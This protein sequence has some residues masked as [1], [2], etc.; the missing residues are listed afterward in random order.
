MVENSGGI[1]SEQRMCFYVSVN[2]RQAKDA[3]LL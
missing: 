3:L 1:A 2:T